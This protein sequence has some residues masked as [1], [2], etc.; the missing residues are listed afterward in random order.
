MD[1]TVEIYALTDPD[2]A[3][4]RYIGKANNSAKRLKSHLRDARRRDTP[5]YRWI[6]ELLVEGRVPGVIVLNS[7]SEGTWKAREREAIA[8]ARA[9]GTDLLN[10]ADGGDQPFCSYEVRSENG[11]RVASL[12]TRTPRQARIYALKRN[13]GQALKRGI[14]SESNKTKMRLAAQKAP[15]IFG[16][17]ARIT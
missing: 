12:R 4:I 16:E 17:W 2:T 1:Q 13:L 3:A 6:R 5:L 14:L 15:H 9:N 8:D 7:G 11:R 10:V